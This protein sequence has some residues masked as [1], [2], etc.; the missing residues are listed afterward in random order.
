MV[1]IGSYADC[2]DIARHPLEGK[3]ILAREPLAYVMKG[4]Y[5][6]RIVRK[7]GIVVKAW[8]LQGR[9]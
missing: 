7:T 4:D 2:L 5:L 6:E 3:I 9:P 8:L 1:K